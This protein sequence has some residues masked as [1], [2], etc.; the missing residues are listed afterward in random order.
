LISGVLSLLVG[1][2][3]WR[4][5]PLAGTSALGILIGANLLCT[6][7]ALLALAQSMHET[8]RKAIFAVPGGQT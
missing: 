1:F 3:I 7:V 2:L 6:G 4:Q 8:L 5:W